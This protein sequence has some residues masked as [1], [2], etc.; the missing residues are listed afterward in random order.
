MKPSKK[1]L[2]PLLTL[3]ILTACATPS[4]PYDPSTRP[5]FYR[6]DP[7]YQQE[8]SQENVTDLT[9]PSVT[10]LLQ[11]LYGMEHLTDQSL[12]WNGTEL[13]M[14][15]HFSEDVALS[16]IDG[17]RSF[18]LNKFVLGLQSQYNPSAY[19]IWMRQDGKIAE[20][21]EVICRVFEGDTLILQ[22]HYEGNELAGYYENTDVYLA[23]REMTDSPPE[24]LDDVKAKIEKETGS[25]AYIQKTIKNE[26]LMVLVELKEE[27]SSDLID[28]LETEM[29]EMAESGSLETPALVLSVCR[30]GETVF[31]S[32]LKTETDQPEWR[33]EEWN[34]Q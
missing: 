5:D 18:A 14:E 7:L 23:C 1:I 11:E 27:P 20:I 31:R 22:E 28:K 9:D 15:Y 12:L 16:E 17:A 29:S 34:T 21:P 2:A 6:P 25:T 26:T 24:I 32:V 10:G 13:Q 8:L 33:N 3:I 30:E 4:A 19:E